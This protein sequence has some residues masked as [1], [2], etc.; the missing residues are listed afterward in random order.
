VLVLS[1][2]LIEV[3][4]P[5]ACPPDVWTLTDHELQAARPEFGRRAP[6]CLV[7]EESLLE[8]PAGAE[9][10]EWFRELHGELEPDVRVLSS[11]RLKALSALEPTW[12][13]ADLLT[14][15]TPV[16][17]PTH[18]RA[19]RVRTSGGVA[20][21]FDGNPAA[22]VD[23]S[24]LGGRVSSPGKAPQP[25]QRMSLML[26]FGGTVLQL[27]GRV[28]WRTPGEG[29]RA[30]HHIGMAFEG[31]VPTELRNYIARLGG[32]PAAAQE[33]GGMPRPAPAPPA[34]RC[35]AC[36]SPVARERASTPDGDAE[37]WW[38]DS[39]SMTWGFSI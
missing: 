13:S 4:G 31:R 29:R 3:W 27:R 15:A 10:V 9:L 7:F 17:P 30:E 37:L 20:A 11:T 14:M 34:H 8:T 12:S 24:Y 26:K 25:G 22:L 33:D 36:Q 28:V 35:P 32:G 2:S 1:D 18:R 5:D 19:A 21:I 6:R 23:L 39:C 38:C 16:P